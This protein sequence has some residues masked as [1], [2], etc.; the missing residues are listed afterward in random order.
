MSHHL[1][2]LSPLLSSPLMCVKSEIQYKNSSVVKNLQGLFD[3]QSSL[4]LIKRSSHPDL[5]RISSQTVISLNNFFL[6][7]IFL[8]LFF[9]FHL[10]LI[11]NRRIY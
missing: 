6:L 9:S 1:D 2:S 11:N 7:K 10:F 5:Q 3:E 8:F 4:P